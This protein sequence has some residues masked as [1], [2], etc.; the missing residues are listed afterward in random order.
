MGFLISKEFPN[1]FLSGDE[2]AG[3]NT[4]V[5]I[6]EVKKE[7]AHS[8][9]TQKEEHVLVVY[10]E[11]KDR[12]VCLGKERAKELRTILASD[13]T[14]SWKGKTVNIFTKKKYAFGKMNNVLHFKKQGSPVE[15]VSDEEEEQILIDQSGLSKELDDIALQS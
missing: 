1:R 3:K 12:G 8:P 2:V 5:V 14:D 6:R 9:K 10:F 11:G 15:E 13:D 4:D 7:K